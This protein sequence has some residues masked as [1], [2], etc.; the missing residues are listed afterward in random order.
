MTYL[1][2][3]ITARERERER[4]RERRREK[5]GERERERERDVSSNNFFTITWKYFAIFWHQLRRAN[6]VVSWALA[7]SFNSTFNPISTEG[8][9]DK[10]P[11]TSFNWLLL[12]WIR[13]GNCRFWRSLLWPLGTNGLKRS[14]LAPCTICFFK[15]LN[16]HAKLP[17]WHK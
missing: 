10:N 8:A 9:K 17:F 5:E 2:T 13:R 1:W 16:R 12:V 4:E 15:K 6:L 11:Q 3:H 7:V 14:V